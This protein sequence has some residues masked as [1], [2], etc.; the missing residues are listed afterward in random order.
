MANQDLVQRVADELEIRNLIANLAVLGDGGDLKDYAKLLA[1]D[2]R[3]E[4]A[5]EPGKAP[6]F[7][8]VTG[9]DNV[10]AAAKK[11]RDDNI[12][13]P[14]THHYHL[15]NTIAVEVKGDRAT[16]VTYLVFLKNA[17]TTRDVAM[18][19]IYR[20]A[21]TRAAD[22]WKLAHRFIDLP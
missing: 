21:F 17:H 18:F 9:R 11:R 14:G 6:L 4:M 16:A 22:G 7:A 15:L 19:R 13:G 1:D 20:D 2:L 3:W 12:S 10:L 8:P 5:A